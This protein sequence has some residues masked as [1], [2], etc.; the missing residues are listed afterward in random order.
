MIDVLP[1]GSLVKLNKELDLKMMI[2]GY[3]MVNEEDGKFYHY[4][5]V[6][7]PRGICNEFSFHLFNAEDIEEVVY[8]GYINK[9][10]EELLPALSEFF[11][12]VS[13]EE[14]I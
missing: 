14:V 5:G 7:Y 9:S 8:K 6:Y 13:N 2:T 3:G 4:S 11:D 1:I 12:E 10:S